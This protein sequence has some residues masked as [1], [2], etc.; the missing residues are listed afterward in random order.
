MDGKAIDMNVVK[1]KHPDVLEIEPQVFG[2]DRGFFM[3]TY[4]KENFHKAGICYD[5][6]Q[7]NHSS[8]V[9]GTL[10]GLHYQI[11]HVQGKLVRVIEGEI[12]DVAVDL[13]KKF[14]LL[15]KMGGSIPV[16]SEQETTLGTAWLWT[17]FL[18]CQYHGAG[19][20]QSNRLL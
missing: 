16:C 18:Y 15:W 7:D 10:R 8:S 3:E 17:W 20:I 2:D 4:Q 11:R 14:S 9:K 6:V 19:F 12:F 13:R 5:F 1:T